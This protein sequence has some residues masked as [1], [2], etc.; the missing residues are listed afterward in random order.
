[1][2]GNSIGS[3]FKFTSFG[4]SH[5]PAVGGVIDGCPSNI[6]LDM[7]NIQ[8]EL[9]RRKPAQSE[10]STS[11]NEDDTVEFLSGLFEGK[12]LGTPIA[13]IIKNKDTRSSDYENL[14][15]VFRPS[16]ADYT[17]FKKYGIR[18]HRGGGRSSARETA[19]RVV[20]GAIAK[21]ILK[22]SGIRI[23]GFV[24]QVA[25][26]VLEKSYKEL[27][28]KNI[29]KNMIRCPDAA[30]AKKMIQKIKEAAKA[31]DTVGG[32]IS[33][34]AGNVPPGLG[35]PVFS[36]L[37]AEL[38]KA[39]LS[40][41]A[42]KGFEIGSGFASAFMN[43]SEHNDAFTNV[44]GKISTKTNHSGGI[45]GGISNGE[46]IF[47]RAAFKPVSSLHMEQQTVDVNLKNVVFNIKGRHD[48]CVLPRAV[49]VV[50]AMTALVLLDFYLQNG[51]AINR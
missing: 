40:I 28:L 1:M 8:Y 2:S 5:G 4:E 20:A 12:T 16:H 39:I 27:D 47:F 3:V 13:F 41:P 44:K 10:I 15:H 31:R 19:A 49:P 30:A 9:N 11:R 51:S 6:V 48:P 7:K 36:K 17:Y 42:C 29:E 35:E 14:K 24:S 46:D 50:E 21:Q 37:H 34:I 25:D 32:V 45:Q 23:T 18:D 38:G 26:I 22:K 33:C 43:G